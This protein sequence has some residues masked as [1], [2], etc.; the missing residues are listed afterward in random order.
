VI[1]SDCDSGPREILAPGSPARRA[2]A[3][4][5]AAYGVLMPPLSGRHLK[6]WEGPEKAEAQ[7]A[8]QIIELLSSTEARAVYER[9]GVARASDF[10]LSKAVLA[11]KELLTT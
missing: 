8:A 1:S 9:A 7:W 6:A 4:E 5:K 3:P 2:A 10:S 11:W